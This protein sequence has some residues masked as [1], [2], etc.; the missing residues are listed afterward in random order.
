MSV[1]TRV[2]DSEHTCILQSMVLKNCP[3]MKLARKLKNTLMPCTGTAGQK[4]TANHQNLSLQHKM[5]VYGL[6]DSDGVLQAVTCPVVRVVSGCISL[7]TCKG[8]ARCLQLT[9]ESLLHVCL[10]TAP[11]DPGNIPAC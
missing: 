7:G 3:M 11:W 9:P 10:L 4:S 8:S 5:A 6:Q 2:R 1:G